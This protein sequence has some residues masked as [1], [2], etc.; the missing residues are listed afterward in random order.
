VV[1]DASRRDMLGQAAGVV[2]LVA[3][4]AAPAFADGAV[5]MATVQRARGIYGGRIADLTDAVEKGDTAAIMAE[6]NA[7]ALFVSGGYKMSTKE[8]SLALPP[9]TSFFVFFFFFRYLLSFYFQSFSSRCASNT[10]N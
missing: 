4:G 9:F 3:A 7:F 5:S 1:V 8:V 2:G 6:K 10:K